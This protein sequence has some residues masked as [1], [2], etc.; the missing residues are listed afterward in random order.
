MPS[1]TSDPGRR[2]ARH[3]ERRDT[4]EPWPSN[5]LRSVIAGRRITPADVAQR[6]IERLRDT[7]DGTVVTPQD[8]GYAAALRIWNRDRE[9]RP[10][11]IVRCASSDDV[12]AALRFAR[13]QDLPIAVRGGGY[14]P[15]GTATV[16]D[17]VVLDMRS[18]NGV[19]VRG[20][21]AQVGAGAT[22]GQLDAY[23]RNRG[24]A[25]PGLPLSDI[26]VGGSTISAGY[27]HL[28]RAYGLACDSLASATLVTAEGVRVRAANDSHPE[29]LWG[30]RGGGGNFGVLTSLTFRMHPVPE[31]I[32]GSTVV[33]RGDDARPLLRFYR[34]WTATLTDDVTSR[35]TLV[36]PGHSALAYA[37]GVDVAV[38][39]VAIS[40]VSLAHPSRA[41]KH[42]H[43]LAEAGGV[44]ARRRTEQP[45]A[46]LQSSIDDAY[47]PGL[48]AEV[49]SQY[50]DRLDDG[51]VDE[52]TARFDAMPAGACELQIDHM[53]GAVERVAP[54][55][56]AAP[57]RA[58][59]Y[60]VTGLARWARR[61]D[62]AAPRDW[63]RATQVTL[64]ARGRAGPHIGMDSGTASST[65]AYGAER[66]VRLAVLKSRYDPDNVFA[67]NLNVAPL[68]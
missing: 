17:G 30:L 33:Y 13:E 28:R 43:P 5:E 9:E 26:G 2:A 65:H 47:L 18:I 1:E 21:T 41:D 23:S 56:S 15:S 34:D 40:A 24:L 64:A 31:S 42:L 48:R 55:S 22:W 50:F 4:I 11:V 68:T 35:M 57:H 63:L 51:A 53:G 52:L 38:R 61:A 32:A 7:L 62:S 27:G 67:R 16:A 54:M 3:A 49:S 60:L 66:H 29:L 58:A 10:A 14:T 37:F 44:L 25:V 6:R 36:G 46:E 45:Y 19:T 59:N 12:V 39:F 8:S 20:P